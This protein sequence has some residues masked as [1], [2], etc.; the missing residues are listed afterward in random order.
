MFSSVFPFGVEENFGISL[1][2]TNFLLKL[3]AKDKLY[4]NYHY[5]CSS[6][7]QFATLPVKMF[8]PF[9]SAWCKI[10]LAEVGVSLP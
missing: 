9:W 3:S 6:L 2:W 5:F 7:Y 4:L 8:G 1:S 10:A